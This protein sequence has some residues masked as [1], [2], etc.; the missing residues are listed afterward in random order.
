LLQ[1]NATHDAESRNALQVSSELAF[2]PATLSLKP[3][4]S[5]FSSATQSCFLVPVSVEQTIPNSL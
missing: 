5:A 1:R 2:S 3:A 4:F